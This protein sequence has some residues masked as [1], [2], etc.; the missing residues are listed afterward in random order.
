M[1]TSYNDGAKVA[2]RIVSRAVS[3]P[4]Y[5]FLGTEQG[6]YRNAKSTAKSF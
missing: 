1:W 3:P 5:L 2:M 6:I 4:A